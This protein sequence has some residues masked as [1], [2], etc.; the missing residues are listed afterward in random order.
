MASSMRIEIGSVTSMQIIA[1]RV[2]WVL[3]LALM[4]ALPSIHGA[5][6]TGKIGLL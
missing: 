2:C 3:A 6:R 1:R 4:R 5:V